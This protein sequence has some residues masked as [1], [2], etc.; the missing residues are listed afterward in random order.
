MSDEHTHTHT[1]LF[2]SVP[3][4]TSM[5]SGLFKLS[6]FGCLQTH[7]QLDYCQ[8]SF[9]FSL[10]FLTHKCNIFKSAVYSQDCCCVFAMCNTYAINIKKGEGAGGIFSV[11]ISSKHFT[12]LAH[13]FTL[14]QMKSTICVKVINNDHLSV[15][16]SYRCQLL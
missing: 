7:E 9:F 14:A 10:L 6:Q 3:V 8:I 5:F 13:T 4:A 15:I 12:C 1:L 11:D 16:A 2:F